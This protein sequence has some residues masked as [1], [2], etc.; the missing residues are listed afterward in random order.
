MNARYLHI[1]KVAKEPKLSTMECEHDGCQSHA[2]TEESFVKDIAILWNHLLK[3]SSSHDSTEEDSQF[4]S[5][6]RETFD[7]S[8]FPSFTFSTGATLAVGIVS[9]CFL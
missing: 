7:S 5:P 4:S 9:V 2:L 8:L 1:A 3:M 6:Q